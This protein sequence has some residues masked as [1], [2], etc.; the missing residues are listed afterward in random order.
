MPEQIPAAVREA[1]TA[2][3]RMVA[4]RDKLLSL[5]ARRGAIDRGRLVEIDARIGGLLDG[6]LAHLDPCDASETEP[7]V[8]LPVRLETR[9]GKDGQKATLR[10]R[11]Y[12]DEIHV[13]SLV[14]GLTLAETTAGRAYW[15]A[16]WTDPVPDGAWDQLVASVAPDRAEWVAHVC[17]PT[18]LGERGTAATPAFAQPTPQGIRNAVARALPDR[19]VVVAVQGSLT[20]QAV[21][22]P[23]PRD[24]QISPIPLDD[25]APMVTPQGIAVPPGSE[26]LVDY[27]AAVEVGMAVTVTLAKANAPVDRVIAMGTRASA[28][29]ASGADELEDVLVGHRFGD[30][31]GLLPQGTPTNNADAA[32]S[33]Y[34]SR[35]TPAAPPLTPPV[36]DP[37]S[38]TVA[39]A[40]AMG[41]D[42]ALLTGLVGPGTGEQSIARQVNTALWAPGWGDYLNRL[43]DNQVPGITDEQR[44]SAR[45]LFRD[46]VRGRGPS[47]ALRVGAQPYG[48]LPVSNLRSWVPQTGETTA[49]IVHVVRTVMDS[50]LYAARR[51]VPLVRPG[52]P[53]IDKTLLDVLGSSPVMQGLRVRPVISEWASSSVIP[54]IGFD[55]A[56]YASERQSAAAVAASLLGVNAMRIA[57]GS[58]HKD[59]RPLPL[60]LVSPRDGEYLEALLGS[61]SRHLAIDSVLQ[62]LATLAWDSE[63][64]DVAKAS[65]A[66]V[67]P[68]LIEYV[69]LDPHLKT[70]VAAL[71]AR[72]DSAS[73]DELHVMASTVQ[74]KGAMGGPS[75]LREFQPIE[76]LRTSLAEVA[77][78]APV[79]REA[80]EVG[81]SAIASWIRAMGYRREVRDA[82]LALT[83]TDLEDRRLAVAEALDCTSHRLDAWVTAVVG[84]RRSMQA[85][86]TATRSARGPRGLTI[87]A[88]GVVEELS[89]A[90][91]SS[92][93]GWIH[94][95]SPRHAVAAGMLRSSH[96]SHLP[97]TGPAS[98]GGPFAI[99]LSSVRLQSAAHVIEGVR[100]GQQ[101]GALIG[102]QLE[103]GLTDARL[104]RLQLS[105][106]TIAPLVARRLS[107]RD[108]TDT[109]AAQESV[110]ATNVVDGLLLLH[111]HPP[112][113][114]GLRTKLNVRPENV[115]LDPGVPW[116]ALTQT[117][118]NA[119]TGLLRAAADTVDAVADVMLSESV[120]QFAGGNPHR[121][122]AAMD[123][124]STGASPSDTIDVLEAQD[125]AE[126]LTHRV[127]AVIGSG[128]PAT[129]WSATRPRAVAEPRLEAWA[130]EHLGDP[131]KVVLAVVGG[132][133]VTLDQAG[134]AALDLVYAV[135]SASLDRAL[136]AAV[137]DLG[138]AELA[139]GRDPGWPK[140]L[141]GLGQVVALAGTLRTLLSGSHVAV[142]GDLTRSGEQ[143]TRDLRAAMT[144]LTARVTT[145]AGSLQAT[146]T[147][148][149]P[150]IADIPESDI[151]EDLD[152]A[153]QLA[154]AVFQL[155]AFGIPL[156]PNPMLPL[157]VSWV[158]SAWLGADA[159]SRNAQ[160]SVDRLV[161]LPA[162]TPDSAILDCAQDVATGVLG[163]G[164]LVLPVLEAGPGT[165]P[166]VEAVNDPAFPQ[167]TAM[168]VRRLVRDLGTVRVPVGR[169]SE[170]LL[171]ESALGRPREL[172]VA[173]TSERTDTGPA[174]GTTHWLAGPLPAEGP[175]PAA[176]VTHFILDTVGT[177]N[178]AAPLAG[179]V[180]DA[181]VEDLPAQ[182]GPKANP[183]D[184]RPG[185]ARTGL[186]IRANAASARP[187]QTVLCAVSADGKR[188]TTDSLRGVIEH[189]L[190]LARVRMVTLERLAGE[191]LMLPALYVR[192][193][194]L[195]GQ[196]YL[197][198]KELA[199]LHTDFVAMPFVKELKP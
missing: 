104:G 83:K 135:E 159:R 173:Q 181:W 67:L 124:M 96:L 64:L 185:R 118:W 198:F 175:W 87:G 88:Y 82:L 197:V 178:A 93:D 127:L 86:R 148:L 42:P 114:E 187:P 8:L 165:D 73:A 90:A 70:L 191:G 52:T 188:W 3:A 50:W 199:N 84:E 162:K 6:V 144:E 65:P 92:T 130:A 141:R 110:A 117:E 150:T 95:P 103:R 97:T 116:P 56:F 48:I 89:P 149:A 72:A 186:A 31:L 105:L 145:L 45:G 155:D 102:Y 164:F 157:D 108:R 196:K 195:Q 16:V 156:Q 29:P 180:I 27:A 51:K 85:A 120:L 194:S 24:L 1:R 9:F 151:V 184:P 129:G 20:A 46:Q 69:D 41:L 143:P 161:G 99:D 43:S 174:L 154:L 152:T 44:E 128:L 146:V 98:A 193:A 75:M 80:K 138:D 19:F 63:E 142:P 170:A 49:G 125:S 119:V 25:E 21:G 132:Q 101:L 134:F 78:A 183:N 11:I 121:A 113:D 166:F 136:R 71:V 47:P 77:L 81:V 66:S 28:S 30:G 76:G 147:A 176:P 10:V 59:D 139:L 177:I 158:R 189:T 153:E 62:A 32:R 131:T 4:E 169:L 33:P 137:L 107:D 60:P 37:A 57:I 168:A 122:A 58:L 53:D 133:R 94:A 123:A 182:V 140:A 163:D 17:T 61:P 172:T 34:R 91:A 74:G 39:A 14:R 111:L 15:T 190:D 54:A 13:D 167:P 22:K 179:I 38:D 160:A 26:W 12:P 112:G 115:Y 100:Q 40:T 35:R 23:I 18:N 106:R 192:S 126:R 79:T 68:T 55:P 171:L 36:A 109:Q 5:G 7:L 2:V